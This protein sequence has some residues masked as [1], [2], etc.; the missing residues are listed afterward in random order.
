MRRVRVSLVKNISLRRYMRV[1]KI[2]RIRGNVRDTPRAIWTRRGRIPMRTR[3]GYSLDSFRLFLSPGKRCL[4][5][6]IR[7]ITF[8]FRNARACKK[9]P[10]CPT[11]GGYSFRWDGYFLSLTWKD[12]DD[13]PDC[14]ARK[15]HFVEVPFVPADI[16]PNALH[17]EARRWMQLLYLLAWVRPRVLPLEITEN[18]TRRQ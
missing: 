4:R 3:R 12:E 6:K 8:S 16:T 14:D 1:G 18:R 9:L 5:T 7:G 15:V 13:N 2:P 17:T 10:R 11:R